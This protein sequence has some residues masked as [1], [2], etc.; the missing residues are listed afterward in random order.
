MTTLAT[1][2]GPLAAGLARTS[3]GSY[4]PALIAV[5]LLCAVAAVSLLRASATDSPH[6]SRE[7]GSA[8][9]R[10]RGTPETRESLQ[11][12]LRPVVPVVQDRVGV[13][14]PQGHE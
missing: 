7:A 1:T 3:T 12:Q 11:R 10:D 14:L 6:R 4:T 2:V 8:P 13:D 5:A 9:R